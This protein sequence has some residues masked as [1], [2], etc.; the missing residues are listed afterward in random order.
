MCWGGQESIQVTES[1]DAVTE[2]TIYARK[3]V[4]LVNFKM[5]SSQYCLGNKALS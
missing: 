4:K 3:K 2:E 5:Y 1:N